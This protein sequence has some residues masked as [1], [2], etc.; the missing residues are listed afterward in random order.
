VRARVALAACAALLCGLTL[1]A[2]GGSS[3]S[4]AVPKSTPYITPPTNTSAE[5]AAAQTTSTSTTS[6]KTTKASET[7]ASG[8][9]APSESSEASSNAGT[10]STEGTSGGAA[11]EKEKPA[12]ATKE[13]SAG[14]TGGASAP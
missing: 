9:S 4:D 7:P 5:V 3:V 13:S 8:E 11:A 2:C 10:P 1:G 14:P 6:A 12:E